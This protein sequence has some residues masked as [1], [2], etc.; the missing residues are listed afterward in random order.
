MTL[1]TPDDMTLQSLRSLGILIQTF[2][3]LNGPFLRGL[4]HESTV[5]RLRGIFGFP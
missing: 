5:R 2:G 1:L 4:P 3:I